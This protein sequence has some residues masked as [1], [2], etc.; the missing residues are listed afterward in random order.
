MRRFEDY[1]DE[2][3]ESWHNELHSK[4]PKDS[5]TKASKTPLA[6]KHPPTQGLSDLGTPGVSVL[7]GVPHSQNFGF[8]GAVFSAPAKAIGLERGYHDARVVGNTP[9]FLSKVPERQGSDLV[10]S[11]GG[12]Q[13]GQGVSEPLWGHVLEVA[14][15]EGSGLQGQVN[16][17]ID[18]DTVCDWQVWS[19]IKRVCFFFYV[20]TRGLC[21][22][23]LFVLTAFDNVGGEGL[24]A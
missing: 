19:S 6:R 21:L 7:S 22:G 20:L 18:T 24:T 1:A 16:H 10:F 17:Q 5:R 14:Q 23:Y 13:S 3:L 2:D 11:D 9:N 15:Q 4:D 8:G 12:G